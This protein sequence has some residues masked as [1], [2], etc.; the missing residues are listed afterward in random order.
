MPPLSAKPKK[1]APTTGLNV[2]HATAHF[3]Q[4]KLPGVEVNWSTGHG[5]FRTGN[6]IFCFIT[7]EGHL[8][9]KLPKER[10][11]ELVEQ[12]DL[13]QLK[14]G[15]RTLKEWLVVPISEE[16]AVRAFSLMQEAKAFVE[17]APAKP[18][19]KVV[20]KSATK[21]HAAKKKS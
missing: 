19:R 12:G 6:K 18:P 20:K 16:T 17:S 9:M 5:S 7:R 2:R 8:A 14:M 1:P 13:R 21:K 4:S 10:I 3:I 11:A 15:E